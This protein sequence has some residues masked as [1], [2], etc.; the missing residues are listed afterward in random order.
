MKTELIVSTV[1]QYG[2][3]EYRPECETS[4]HFA[5]LLG[6]KHLTRRN[7][8]TIKK[9]GFSFRTPSKSI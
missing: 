3:E 5:E 1:Q 6:Q 8:D 2:R 7:I 4:K 9:M